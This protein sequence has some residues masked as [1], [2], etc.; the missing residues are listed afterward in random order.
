MSDR[1]PDRANVGSVHGLLRVVHH[2]DGL[3][4]LLLACCEMLRS[5]ENPLGAKFGERPF[6]EVG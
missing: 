5:S 4:L 3:S 2:P 1:R 6:Y